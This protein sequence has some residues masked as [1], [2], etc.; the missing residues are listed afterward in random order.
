VTMMER[1]GMEVESFGSSTGNMNH[2][3]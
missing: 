1:F 3:F 2:A